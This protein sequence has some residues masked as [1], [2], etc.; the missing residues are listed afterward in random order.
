MNQINDAA[1][2]NGVWSDGTPFHMIRTATGEYT[3]YFDSRIFVISGSIGPTASGRHFYKF[4]VVQ[5]GQVRVQ[6][7]DATGAAENSAGFDLTLSV[8][9]SRT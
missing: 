3:V 5:A 6:T 9:D 8:L 7:L 1:S 2:S 4:E